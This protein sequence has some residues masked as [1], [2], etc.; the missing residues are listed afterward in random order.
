MSDDLICTSFEATIGSDRYEV[1]VSNRSDEAVHSYL[2]AFSPKSI[3]IIA[4]SYFK[5]SSVL[6][7]R[8]FCDLLS[9]HCT[10][11]VDGGVEM[12]SLKSLELICDQ[13]FE[14]SIPRDGVIVA[15]GGGVV[16]DLAAMASSIYQRG[17]KLIHIPTTTTSMLDSSIGGKTGVNHKGQVN[18]LGTYHNPDALFCDSRFLRTLP[19]RDLIAGICESIKKSL[20]SDYSAVD[21]FSSNSNKILALDP[22]ALHKMICWSIKQKLFFVSSDFKESSTR[23]LLNYGHTFGQAFESFYG[24]Y[25]DYLRHGEAV[26]LGICCAGYLTDKVFDNSQLNN[27]QAKLLSMYGLPCR[28]SELSLPS[29]PLIS[30][31]TPLLKNDKKRV[32]TGNRFVLLEDIGRPHILSDVEDELLSEAFDVVLN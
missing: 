2:S 7:S 21:F 3:F 25:Q 29:L 24:L 12:K 26:S 14:S 27:L 9:D 6:P 8:S 1:I 5:N 10:Y 16:G 23:L 11:Y 28:I 4:D 15:L 17:M 18:L 22:D 32:S 30:Q 19:Q 13:L 20:I 31:L